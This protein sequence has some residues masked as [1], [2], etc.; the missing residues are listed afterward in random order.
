MLF[1]PVVPYPLQRSCKQRVIV[2]H[3]GDFTKKD[4][5]PAAVVDLT[6]K[7]QE[8]IEPVVW[9]RGVA[10][11]LRC[12]LCREVLEFLLFSQVTLVTL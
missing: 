8:G 9:H 7:A 12:K 10:L 5:G 6:V 3:P 1:E 11:R 2:G 4:N